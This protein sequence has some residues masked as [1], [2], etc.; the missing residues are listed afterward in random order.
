MPL[1]DETRCKCNDI[2]EQEWHLMP[3]SKKALE[4]S[5]KELGW[6]PKGEGK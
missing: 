4:K 1:T 2:Y 6:K 3:K 5:R